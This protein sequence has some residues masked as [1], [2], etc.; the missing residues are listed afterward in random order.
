MQG[1]H[2]IITAKVMAGV[3]VILCGS[4]SN[5]NGVENWL[6]NATDRQPFS[7]YLIHLYVPADVPVYR[8]QQRNVLLIMKQPF[9]T[10]VCCALIAM[11]L[12]SSSLSRLL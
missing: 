4:A 5:V 7:R 11:P 6:N 10:M 1:L 8:R 2:P 3:P 12:W 9:P